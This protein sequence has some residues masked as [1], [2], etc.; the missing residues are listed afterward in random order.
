[1][2]LPAA[3]WIVA[4][5]SRSKGRHVFSRNIKPMRTL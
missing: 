3:C 1:V 5:N 2:T 4:Q